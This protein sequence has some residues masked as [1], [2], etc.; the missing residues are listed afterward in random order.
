MRKLAGAHNVIGAWI[1]VQTGGWSVFRRLTYLDSTSI[2]NEANAFVALALT[3]DGMSTEQAV[4][5]FCRN[6]LGHADWHKLLF[7][8]RLSE[9][10][11]KELLY[12]EQ[13]ARRKLFYRR[14]RVPPLLSVLWDQVIVNHS[15]RK[16]L[17]CLVEDPEEAILQGRA[18]LGK[19]E[20]MQRLASELGLPD[21]DIAFQYDTFKILATAREY[22]FGRFGPEIV[23]ELEHLRRTYL[24]KYERRYTVHLDFSPFP[25]PRRRIGRVLS[26]WIRDKRGYRLID[27]ILMIGV[28]SWLS[29]VFL[30]ARHETTSDLLQNQAM[31]ID[32]V[33]K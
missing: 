2:W 9:E 19:I 6:R 12:V 7:L 26:L 27:R 17:R 5:A 18:A 14:L 20:I 21:S 10:V 30:I 31:G 13:M 25:F 29:P 33:M 1:W 22:Y 4:E 11:V 24:R 15:M 3:R 28:L 32:T 16:L 8:L 23:R